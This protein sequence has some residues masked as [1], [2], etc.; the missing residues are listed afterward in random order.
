MGRPKLL[1]P[2]DGRTADRPRRDR[3]C[4]RVVPI[5]WWSSPRRTIPR[6]DRPSLP[7]GTGA[8]AVVVAPR[9]R[10]AE[11]RDSIEIGLETLARSHT[12]PITSC[13]RPETR[14]A[15]RRRSSPGFSRRV[16]ASR[17]RSSF[18]AVATAADTRSCCRGSSPPRLRRCPRGQGVNALAGPASGAR[19][20]GSRR[21]LARRGRHRHARTTSGGGRATRMTSHRGSSWPSSASRQAGRSLSGAAS[22]SS[23]WRGSVP[24]ARRSISI[25]RRTARV[26][27]LRAEIARRLPA[28]APFMKNV[29]IAVN[30]EYADDEAHDLARRAGRGDPARQR[31]SRGE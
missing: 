23:R 17:R 29:M 28:L 6:R 10:P 21:R 5:A 3:T 12:R 8:G 14:P 30:E 16:P 25:W 24:A 20:R 1:L 19:G 4:A 18:H 31:R 11:M 13:W 22:D 15:S 26:S 7:R 27:D 9:V 2:I